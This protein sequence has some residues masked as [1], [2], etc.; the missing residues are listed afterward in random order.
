MK[1]TKK[2]KEIPETVKHLTVNFI[3][4]IEMIERDISNEKGKSL[5]IE[6]VRVDK[7]ISCG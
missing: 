7:S 4:L 5:S 3:E 1:S 2:K 6:N